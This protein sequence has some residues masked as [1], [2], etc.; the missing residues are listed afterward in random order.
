MFELYRKAVFAWGQ[1]MPT[2]LKH[3]RDR[4]D[5]SVYAALQRVLED[6]TSPTWEADSKIAWSLMQG[7]K[8][9]DATVCE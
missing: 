4:S 8:I 3:L 7:R 9:G 2:Q 6:V 1:A 5:D